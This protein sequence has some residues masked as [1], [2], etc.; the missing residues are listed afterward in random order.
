ML[1][2]VALCCAADS[3]TCLA[4]F[5]AADDRGAGANPAA[6]AGFTG[7]SFYENHNLP[8][9]THAAVHV[10]PQNWAIMGASGIAVRSTW[11]TSIRYCNAQQCFDVLVRLETQPRWFLNNWL[12]THIADADRMGKARLAGALLAQCFT[13]LMPTHPLPYSR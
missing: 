8:S 10:W 9:I 1:L 7:Q 4:G 13:A 11:L 12:S 3:C 2:L 5:F 6:W